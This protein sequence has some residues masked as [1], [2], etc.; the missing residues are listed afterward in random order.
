MPEVQANGIRFHYQ[1]SGEGPDVVLLHAVTSNL[2]VWMFT[3]LVETLATQF[4][5][6]LY[7]FRG[8]GFSERPP[9]GYT[10]RDMAEDFKSLHESL[11]LKPAILVGHSFGGVVGMHAAISSPERVAGVIL[12]DSFFPGLRDIEPNFGRMNIWADLRETFSSVDVDLG[13]IVDFNRLFCSAA[14]LS[15]SQMKTL[16][17]KVGVFGQGW[18]RQL[19][20]LA[21]TTC[22]NDVLTE[23]GLTAGKIAGVRQP[24]AALYD[25]F[26]PFLATCDWL[27]A[28]LPQCETEII[29]GAKHL[30]MVENTPAFTDAVQRHL[31]RMAGG[32]QSNIG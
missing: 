18:L 1:Q 15:P 5:V 23:A 22:G 21:E 27:K 20:K 14:D 32:Q 2:A 30:A 6:T 17:Q 28:N 24:V 16:E 11:G 4:R 25:E 3:G 10:S 7:D 9:T 31:R 13:E 19:P 29:P 26:S 12:S 8:H